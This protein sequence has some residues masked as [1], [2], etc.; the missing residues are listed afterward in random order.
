[1]N[2]SVATLSAKNVETPTDIFLAKAINGMNVTTTNMKWVSV[3]ESFKKNE[4]HLRSNIHSF[5]MTLKVCACSLLANWGLVVTI[6]YVLC[7]F[8]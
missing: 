7:F 3:V 1:M 8:L 2:A 5:P 4:N 6:I